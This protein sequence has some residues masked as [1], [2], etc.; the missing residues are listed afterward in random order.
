M[1]TV[2]IKYSGFLTRLP[3]DT[4]LAAFEGYIGKAGAPQ[5]PNAA[6]KD[7]KRALSAFLL[8]V[9]EAFGEER[10]MWASDWR[11]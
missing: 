1:P 9:L 5:H 3:H 2:Y 11:E 6:Y 10:I 8:P 4:A 7:C